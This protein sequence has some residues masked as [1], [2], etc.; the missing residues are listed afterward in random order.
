MILSYTF[1]QH[2]LWGGFWAALLCAV[3]GTYVVTRRL[4]IAGGGMA[5]AGLGGV[6]LGAWLGINPLVGAAIFTLFS[7]FSIDFL[8]RRNI[9]EDSA[10]AMLWTFGMAVGILF[11]YLTP[12]F[13]NDLS[14]Y[15]FGDIL[16]ISH[17]D[18]CL[19][20][21]LTALT[22][23]FFLLLSSAIITVAYD[24]NFA[25]TQGLPVRLIE[26][27]MIALIALTIVVCLRMV[28]IVLVISLLSVPQQS[29]ALLT[30][31]FRPMVWLSALFGFAG[32]VGG[33]FLSYYLNVP[34]GASII[35]VSVLLYFICRASRTIIHRIFS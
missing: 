11:A 18:I 29:A 9:R 32:I 25:I 2:A 8:S 4:V 5:H 17:T 27:V 35:L 26:T 21:V 14:A 34:S 10:I 28:G 22:Y 24:R 30:H 33:L 20:A 6:G 23:A 3:I 1:F 31:R 7:G 19:I 13:M 12:G 15:L 16:S